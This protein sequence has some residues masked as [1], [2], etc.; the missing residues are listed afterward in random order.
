MSSLNQTL[1]QVTED[2]STAVKQ[3]RD[4]VKDSLTSGRKLAQEKLSE[5]ESQVI[6][7][8]NKALGIAL[9]AGL[10]LGCML[11]RRNHH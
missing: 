10:A 6:K 2:A 4:S 9:L 5:V 11:S 1:N 7:H 3:A 8:P